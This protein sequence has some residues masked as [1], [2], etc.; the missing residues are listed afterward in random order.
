[1]RSVPEYISQDELEV[2]LSHAVHSHDHKLVVSLMWYR[3]TTRLHK[4]RSN[5]STLITRIERHI[6]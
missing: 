3:Y 4:C 2:E 6:L 5:V 1:M